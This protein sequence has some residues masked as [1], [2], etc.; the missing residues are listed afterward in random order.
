MHL[1][2]EFFDAIC[3]IC[4]C[5]FTYSAESEPEDFL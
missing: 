4:R 3:H 5:E 2:V 1:R